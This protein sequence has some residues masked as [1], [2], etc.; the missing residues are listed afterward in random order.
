M[1]SLGVDPSAQ[2][3]SPLERELRF[4]WII[5]ALIYVTQMRDVF[6]LIKGMIEGTGK[7]RRAIYTVN[8]ELIVP[9]LNPRFQ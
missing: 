4:N 7:S 3:W 8:E 6:C 9:E 2:L 5:A 1:R